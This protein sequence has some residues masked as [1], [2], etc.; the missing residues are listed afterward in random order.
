MRLKLKNEKFAI[1]LRIAIWLR[2]T[3]YPQGGG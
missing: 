2:D 1:W 3:P